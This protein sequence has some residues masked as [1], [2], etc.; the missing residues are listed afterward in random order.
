V[1]KTGSLEIGCFEGHRKAVLGEVPLRGATSEIRGSVHASALVFRRALAE[2]RKTD[3]D[4]IGRW[5]VVRHFK[6]STDPMFEEKVTDVVGLYRRTRYPEEDLRKLHPLARKRDH[7]RVT[8]EL[9]ANNIELLARKVMSR[10]N[11]H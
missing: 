11:I 1:V 8:I 5:N 7:A 4:L 6:I 2:M 3:K 9:L 10:R